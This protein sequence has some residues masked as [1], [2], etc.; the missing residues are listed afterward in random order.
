MKIQ[1]ILL[2]PVINNFHIKI[3]N[4]IFLYCM[5]PYLQ[6]GES[7]KLTIVYKN[8]CT[9]T[10]LNHSSCTLMCPPSFSRKCSFPASSIAFSPSLSFYGKYKRQ[11]VRIKE[12]TREFYRLPPFGDLVMAAYLQMTH[13]ASVSLRFINNLF[14]ICPPIGIYS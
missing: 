4:N 13:D 8:P 5:I 10:S 12:F 1:V 3:Y 7:S 9:M 2:F 11:I 6:K 14:W